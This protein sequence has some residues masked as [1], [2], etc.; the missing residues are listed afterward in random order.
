MFVCKYAKIVCYQCS[1]WAQELF[2]L[3][4]KYFR[5][6]S[7]MCRIEASFPYLLCIIPKLSTLYFVRTIYLTNQYIFLEISFP[8][9]IVSRELC[10]L[11][12]TFEIIRKLWIDL[13][14]SVTSTYRDSDFKK[15]SDHDEHF[16]SHFKKKV[17][18]IL[19]KSIWIW[20]QINYEKLKHYL[21]IAALKSNSTSDWIDIDVTLRR[22]QRP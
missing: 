4:W 21:F 1:S 9:I 5:I 15:F 22:S 7:Y 2:S 14:L 10:T 12:W 6:W 16:P 11:N 19:Y 18:L 13:K 20:I 8:F 17:R 3:Y